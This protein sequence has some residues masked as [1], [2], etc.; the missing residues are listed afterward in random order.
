MIIVTLIV[1]NRAIALGRTRLAVV[2]WL[3][4]SPPTT[5]ARDGEWVAGALERKSFRKRT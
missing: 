4:E 1:V 3:V 5:L 2:R